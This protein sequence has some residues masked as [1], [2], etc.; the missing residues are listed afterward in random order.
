VITVFAPAARCSVPG[1]LADQ[2]RSYCRFGFW[3]NYPALHL[4]DI[5]IAGPDRGT[6]RRRMNAVGVELDVR[7]CGTAGRLGFMVVVR[8]EVHRVFGRG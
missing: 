3:F 4:V 5:F 8:R 7:L 2:P 1:L 6:F